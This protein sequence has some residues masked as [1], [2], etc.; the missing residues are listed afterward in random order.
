MKE[1]AQRLDNESIEIQASS[2]PA[3]VVTYLVQERMWRLEAPY[4]CQHEVH[5]ITVPDQFE[6]DL[7]SV[8]RPFWWLIAPFELSIAAPLLH[9][10]LYRYGGEPPD[11][12]VVPSRSYSRREADLLFRDIMEQEGVSPWRRAAAYRAVRWLGAGAWSANA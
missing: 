4:I 7:A 10:F 5:R 8:P 9:D 1:F 11:G 12:S 3:P 6:F 2:L